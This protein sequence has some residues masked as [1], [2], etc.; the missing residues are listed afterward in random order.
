V[1]VPIYS[2][3]TREIPDSKKIER[4]REMLRAGQRPPPIKVMK[5]AD[6]ASG[7]DP[8]RWYCYDGHHRL[9]A[10]RAEGATHVRAVVVSLVT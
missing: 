1:L 3:V 10:A 4:F 7:N 9:A 5:Y 6:A 8:R 2:I